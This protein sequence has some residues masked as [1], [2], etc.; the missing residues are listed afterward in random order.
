M[1][2]LCDSRPGGVDPL[3]WRRSRRAWLLSSGL[4]L[5]SIAAR[6]LWG[7]DDATGGFVTKPHH[8]PSARSVIVLFMG[9]GPSHVDTFDPKPALAGL[10]GGN[11]PESIARDIPRIARSPLNNLFASPFRFAKH[12]QSGIEVSELYPELARRST[13]PP[14]TFR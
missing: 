11:V 5:G 12:G 10:H 3:E 2:E 8:A 6:Q 7:A 9:G 1:K 4:G 14:N 13:R